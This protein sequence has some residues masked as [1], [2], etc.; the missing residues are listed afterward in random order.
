MQR[1]NYFIENTSTWLIPLCALSFRNH[2]RVRHRQRYQLRVNHDRYTY[3]CRNGTEGSRGMPLGVYI[4]TYFSPKM[5]KNKRYWVSCL[6]VKSIYKIDN[7]SCVKVWTWVVEINKQ[8]RNNFESILWRR[9]A[10]F[11]LKH[12]TP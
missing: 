4:C 12:V 3:V 11:P 1:N 7:Y 8:L 9:D 10:L 2:T 6:I 5:Y